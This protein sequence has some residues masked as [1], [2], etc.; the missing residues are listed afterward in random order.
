MLRMVSRVDGGISVVL[1]SGVFL[2]Q[3]RMSRKEVLMSKGVRF[4]AWYKNTK[5]PRMYEVTDLQWA[6][7]GLSCGTLVDYVLGI[8]LGNVPCSDFELVQWTG[9][10][11]KNGEFIFEGDIVKVP[12]NYI[13]FPTHNAAIE[14]SNKELGWVTSSGLQLKDHSPDAPRILEIVGN[15][16]EHP[17]LLADKP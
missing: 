17:E 3:E 13:S 4:R 14:W 11:D 9:L 5:H 2:I 15:V 10:L 1:R 12:G 8:Q 6:A 7:D 16:Y